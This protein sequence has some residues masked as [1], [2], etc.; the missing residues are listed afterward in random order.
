[1]QKVECY[2]CHQVIEFIEPAD[3]QPMYD[4]K[5]H[6]HTAQAE[7]AG[8]FPESALRF[9]NRRVWLKPDIDR[10][11]DAKDDRKF[12]KARDE[13]VRVMERRKFTPAEKKKIIELLSEK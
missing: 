10:W 7:E 5:T 3:L 13:I 1:M 12:D 4:I 11:V 8:K 9:P 2:H 6:E